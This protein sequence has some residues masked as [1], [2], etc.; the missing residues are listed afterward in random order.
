M[1]QFLLHSSKHCEDKL[2][3]LLLFPIKEHLQWMNSGSF[4]GASVGLVADAAIFVV[5]LGPIVV[6]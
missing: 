5:G 3:G 1:V 4:P 2:P 6:E